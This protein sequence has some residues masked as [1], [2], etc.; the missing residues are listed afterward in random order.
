MRRVGIKKDVS[1]RNFRHSRATNLANWMTEAQMDEYFGWV[2]RSRMASVYIHLS[3]RNLDEVIL[4]I[5]GKIKEESNEQ[6]RTKVCPI[7]EYENAP[8]A[9]FCLKCRRPLSLEAAL[10]AEKREKEL[11]RMITPEMIEQM[12]QR[13]VEEILARYLSKAKL[14]EPQGIKVVV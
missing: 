14:A 1:P 3:G 5:H 12:I 7:C 9:E 11:L 2:L 10:R 8:E 4:R 13:K 6:L